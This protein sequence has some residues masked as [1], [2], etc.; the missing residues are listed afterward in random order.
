M[1]SMIVSFKLSIDVVRVWFF[2]CSVIHVFLEAE[3][4]VYIWQWKFP[5]VSVVS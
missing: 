2:V 5:V 1:T 4:V 3:R